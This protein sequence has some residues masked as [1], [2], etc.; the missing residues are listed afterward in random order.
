MA[1][2]SA[3]ISSLFSWLRCACMP[4]I[5]ILVN[6]MVMFEWCVASCGTKNGHQIDMC[7]EK[8]GSRCQNMLS[9]ILMYEALVSNSQ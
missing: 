5:V 7:L 4:F 9:N 8:I 2:L 1:H 3:I 6:H